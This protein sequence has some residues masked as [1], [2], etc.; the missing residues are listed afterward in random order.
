MIDTNES[1]LTVSG[2]GKRF[3]GIVAVNGV[4]FSVRR[5]AATSLVG[6]NGAGKTTIF[7][8]ITG[9]LT[10]DSGSVVFEGSELVG[11]SPGEVARMGISRTF[12]DLRL[13]PT[14][15]VLETV[16]VSFPEQ[17]GEDPLAV[18]FRPRAVRRQECELCEKADAI[19]QRAGLAGLENRVA[20][21]LG[22]AEQKLL[23][24]SRSM[25][26]GADVWL[27]DEP[28]SGIDGDALI[29][30]ADLLR[31]LVDDGQTVLIVEHNLRLVQKVSDWVLFLDQGQLKAEGTPE[32]IFKNPELLEIY[33][34][35]GAS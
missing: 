9:A 27:L 23:T 33:I 15:T 25:A 30:F 31:G 6:P 34:G 29:Q 28:A 3:G 8:L 32:D 18:I 26:M 24:V 13:F 5:G 1:V 35:G 21:T 20:G 12:Q 11:R 10:A 16:M 17:L 14:M 19:L 4:S 7:N 2:L 22:Y